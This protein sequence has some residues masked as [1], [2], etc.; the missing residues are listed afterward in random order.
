MLDIFWYLGFSFD[1]HF[2]VVTDTKS[3]PRDKWYPIDMI[4]DPGPNERSSHGSSEP[5]STSFS[6]AKKGHNLKAF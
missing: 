2:H 1:F 6:W 4:H 5:R 3:L